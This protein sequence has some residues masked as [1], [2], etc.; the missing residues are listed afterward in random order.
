[1]LVIY[2]IIYLLAAILFASVTMLLSVVTQNQLIV[3]CGMLGYLL[4]DLFAE[5]PD[6]FGVIQKIWLLRPNAVMMNTGFTNY[7]L[8][9]LAGKLFLN[10]QAAPVIYAV[11]SI[12]AL[13]IGRRK[14]RR[15]Q[16]GN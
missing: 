10:F 1:M 9:H 13:L 4:I 8:I 14:Y 7:R 15:L 12:A 16:V 3:T 5:L 2:M 11:I 6:S